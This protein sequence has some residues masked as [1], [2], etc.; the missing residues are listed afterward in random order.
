MQ[1]IYHLELNVA[2][3]VIIG[4][5]GVTSLVKWH[6]FSSNQIMVFTFIALC[7]SNQICLLNIIGTRGKSLLWHTM[8]TARI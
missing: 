4:K 7:V 5:C 1:K 2:P 8:F 6:C 3:T